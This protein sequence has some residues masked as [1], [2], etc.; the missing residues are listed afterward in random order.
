MVLDSVS[1]PL[2]VR[3]IPPPGPAAVLP[4]IV[5]LRAG[6]GA[7]EN[8]STAPP[9]PAVWWPK[10][11]ESMILAVFDER[12]S[13]PPPYS[14]VAVFPETVHPVMFSVPMPGIQTAPPSPPVL[15]AKVESMNVQVPAGP[16]G[17]RVL[18][19]PP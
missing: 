6:T 11:V 9:A 3:Q 15:P 10:S 2:Q 5:A 8:I 13:P 1:P 12:K 18:T 14:L 4:V 7:P 17:A 19:P 16:S